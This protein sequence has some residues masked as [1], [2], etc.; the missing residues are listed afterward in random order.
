[1]FK[2]L[3]KQI[4]P[5]PRNAMFHGVRLWVSNDLKLWAS[6]NFSQ[7][8]TGKA[9]SNEKLTFCFPCAHNNDH[10]KTYKISEFEGV[11]TSWS[12]MRIPEASS[13]SGP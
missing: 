12:I 1:M 13:G 9:L 7:F 3:P 6:F 5:L 10:N 8:G 4:Y 2:M 11:N